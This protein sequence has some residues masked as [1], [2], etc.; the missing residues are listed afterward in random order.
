MEKEKICNSKKKETTMNDVKIF[1]NNSFGK[2]R[3]I[4]KDG[5][6]FFCLSDVCKSLELKNP[7]QVKIRLDS[8]GLISNEVSTSLQNQYGEYTRY[9]QLPP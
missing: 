2:L 6:V 5:K 9:R 3:L 8:A 4:E 1:S 7:S